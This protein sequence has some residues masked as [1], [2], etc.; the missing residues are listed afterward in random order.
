MR[1]LFL[2]IPMLAASAIAGPRPNILF[3]FCDDLGYGDVGVFYQNERKA[4]EPS[5]QTPQI[6][7]LAKGGIQLRAHYCAA[8]VCAP[9]RASLFSGRHQGNAAIRNNQFDKEFPDQPSMASVLQGNGYATALIGKWGL[10][11]EGDSSKTWPAYPTKRGFDYFLGGV[12]HRDGHEHYPADKIHSKKKRIEV[13]EQNTEIGADL[14]NCYTTDLWTAGAKRWIIKQR[15]EHS[16]KP[17][18]LFL[19]FDT[20]HAATQLPPCA[21]PEG[22]GVNG[23]LQWLGKPGQMINT[24]NGKPDSYIHPDYADK[25]WPNVYKRYASSV[26]R[27][28]NCV[29]DLVQTLRDL[30]IDHNTLVVF[31]SDHGPSIESYLSEPFRANF[32]A[33]SGPFTGTKRDVWEGGIRP[34]AIASWPGTIPAGVVSESPSQMHDWLPTFCEISSTPTPALA[35]GTSLVPTLTGKGEQV[36]TTVYVEYSVGGKTPNYQEYPPSKRDRKRREMQSIRIGDFKGIRYNITSAD[37]AFEVYN[38][39]KDPSESKDIA[40]QDGV[41]PQQDWYAAAARMHGTESSAE[42]PY[43]NIQIP[44]LSGIITTAGLNV[45]HS[46]AKVPYAVLLPNT[47]DIIIAKGFYSDASTGN[48]QFTGFIDAPADGKYTFN[49]KSNG[50]IL[51]IHDIVVL[52]TD[53]TGSSNTLGVIHLKKGLHPISLTV[54]HTGKPIAESLLHWTLPEATKATVV[55]DDRLSH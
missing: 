32:F 43:D 8:P 6:D 34:G 51:R 4:G 36:P 48:T 25:D 27:I 21:F 33:S 24:A 18:F 16:D 12:R 50:S 49:L 35:D 15:K 9:S 14:H 19:S 29:G 39:V 7:A 30:K 46:S 11:G 22:Y 1:F 23:G 45:A 55:P 53:S 40:G 37:Q 17:F 52:D 44:A 13:W 47:D 54:R 42:R 10:Q 2:L 20:P 3:I 38:V 26:R 28:D 41:P 5:H 31:S